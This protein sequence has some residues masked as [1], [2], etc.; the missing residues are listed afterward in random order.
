M[1]EPATPF[2]LTGYY[3]AEYFCDRDE[4]TKTVLGNIR[5]GLST[6]LTA[7]R[8]IGK[9]SL[10]MHILAK[11]T[12]GVRTIYLDIL[13]TESRHDFLNNLATALVK[14]IADKKGFGRK[15]WDFIRS[16]GPVLSFDDLSGSPRVSFI[17]GSVDVNE[18]V[19]SILNFLEKQEDKFVIAIDEFQQILNYPDNNT[20]AWLRSIIQRMKNVV[21]IFSGSQQHLMTELFTMPARPFY[22]SASMLKIEKIN[23]SVYADF[24]KRKFL[25]SGK[26]ISADVTKNILRWTDCHTYY[27]QLL[28][29]RVFISGAAEITNEVWKEEASKLLLENEVVFFNYRG[30]LTGPQWQLLKAIGREGEVFEPTSADFI[31]KNRL[32][33]T[34]TVLRSLKSLQKMELIYYD[35]DNVGRKFFKMNDLLFRRWAETKEL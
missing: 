26:K 24:I 27:V 16:L 25:K 2:P 19:E 6:V 34:A 30:M 11:K 14:N 32:G 20:D 33:A 5:N 3:G 18:K 28:C 29:G 10:I 4:E 31:S 23:Q 12:P 35:F 22:N 17:P 7:Q 15:L 1:K 8:R 9:T 21:F 13:A